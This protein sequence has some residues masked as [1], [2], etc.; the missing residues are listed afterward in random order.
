MPVQFLSQAD[1]DQLNRFPQEISHKELNSFFLLS[2]A[3]RQ[4]IDSIR[5]DHNRLGFALQLGCL[6]YLGFF[7]D[8]LLQIPQ[9]VVQY[10]AQQLT[11]VPELLVFYGKRAS[12][13]RHH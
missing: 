4:E 8:D 12:T 7:P 5:G 13:Q 10:V 2:S 11:V 1:H 3:D 6:R 9:I